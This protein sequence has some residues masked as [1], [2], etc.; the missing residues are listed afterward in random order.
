LDWLGGGHKIS[1]AMKKAPIFPPMV[2]LALATLTARADDVVYDIDPVHPG[3]QGEESFVGPIEFAV[4]RSDFGID[5]MPQAL[6]DD[7]E[8][9][10]SVEG[11]KK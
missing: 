10:V 5:D 6:G 11:L 7:V 9:I 8:V 3:L 2:A 1:G 4:Q